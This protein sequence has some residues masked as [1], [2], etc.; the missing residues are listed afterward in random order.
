MS[1]NLYGQQKGIRAFI[2]NSLGS[3]I[4]IGGVIGAFLVTLLKNP[5]GEIG[6]R[7]KLFDAWFWVIWAIVFFIAV[8]VAITN[9]KVAKRDAKNSVDF[10]NTL[11]NYA[12]KK[13]KALKHIDLLPEFVII[14]NK[15]IRNMI[16]RDIVESADL[17][18]SKYLENK[19]D[20]ADLEKWQIKRLDLIKKIK[21]KT[22][23]SK[24]LTQEYVYQK[25]VT[26]SFLPPDEK[27]GERSFVMKTSITRAINTLAFIL[28]GGLTF[29]MIGWVAGI[30]N[31]FG[32]IAAWIGGIIQGYD[33]VDNVLRTRYIAK[34][35]LLDEF[36][37]WISTYKP[38][39]NTDIKPDLN[40]VSTV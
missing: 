6:V 7:D 27:S 32:I 13:E 39:T 5:D 40:T 35:D 15:E 36:L 38:D 14:K 30:I 4:G 2:A 33:Y 9:Y 10:I 29:T 3:I 17:V 21:I 12:D 8:A 25:N 34:S 31:A 24:D 37:N 16:I 11:N 26:Y 23:K 19:Y 28:V 1:N 20:L 22:I 18:Y